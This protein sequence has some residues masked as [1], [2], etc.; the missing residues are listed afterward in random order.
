MKAG[1]GEEGYTIS[2]DEDHDINSE[3]EFQ[4]INHSC[5]PN[6]VWAEEE[7]KVVVIRRISKGE[8]LTVDYGE[9]Y[10]PIVCKCGAKHC[11]GTIGSP[12]SFRDTEYVMIP[13]DSI[14]GEDKT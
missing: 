8:Q 12:Y 7:M 10:H 3:D 1:E 13:Y 4:F 9:G 11:R 14:F 5:Q 2:V 6:T